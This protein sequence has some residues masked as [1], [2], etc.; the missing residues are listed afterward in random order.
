M[1]LLDAG[2]QQRWAAIECENERRDSFQQSSVRS[3]I[4]ALTKSDTPFINTLFCVTLII[5]L[6][7]CI[8]GPVLAW[9]R[10]SDIAFAIESSIV[11][12][13]LWGVL[14]GLYRLFKS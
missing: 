5:S 11:G 1:A 2:E 6:L 12:L 9:L 8:L 10:Q 3:M 4:K 14:L 13:A 7:S